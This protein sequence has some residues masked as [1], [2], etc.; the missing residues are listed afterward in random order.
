M[1]FEF[2]EKR[3][4][5]PDLVSTSSSNEK[6]L[7]LKKRILIP[8]ICFI[9][10][11]VVTGYALS[12]PKYFPSFTIFSVSKGSSLSAIA[13]SLKDGGYIRSEFLF[14]AIVRAVFFSG[15][16]AV[17][18]DYV[19]EEPMSVLRLARRI[20]VGNFNLLAVK[21]TI[22]EG[23]NKFEI[24]E[25]LEKNLPSFNK[26]EFL[27]MA[28]EGYMFPDTYFFMPNITTDGIVYTLENNF[29]QKIQS[30]NEQIEKFGKPLDDVIKIASILETEARTTETRRTIAGILWKRLEKDMPL[31]V[32]VSFKYI[33]GKTTF[34]LTSD[35]LDIDS[36]YNTYK[37]AGL[38][39][40]PISNPGLDSIKAASDP[41]N[42]DY[43]YFLSD[44]EGNMHYGVTFEQ[45]K[46]NKFRY[47]Q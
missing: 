8:I 21:I 43:L 37:Y 47:L 24:S 4:D 7:F 42:T 17:A 6:S 30:V 32:D 25:I 9:F 13:E 44:H 22:P 20:V 46:E 29:N 45:H 41:L 31:Q 3:D 11:F 35:D 34:E 27:A 38:P 40:T 18:G 15:R 26:E 23:L 1:S 36:P 28:K 2:Q 39:P 5:V 19:F 33:N 12:A 10:L 14:K 16:S